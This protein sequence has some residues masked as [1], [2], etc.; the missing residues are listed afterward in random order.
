M[1][2][3]AVIIAIA[4]GCSINALNATN[5]IATIS[6]KEVVVNQTISPFCLS[7]LKGDYETA[8]KLIDLGADINAKSLGLTPAMYAA[9]FNRTDILKL[10][11]EKGAKLK[12]KSDKGMTA[13]KYAELSNATDALSYL[14]QLE[15]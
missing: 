9:K 10:L 1:K 5:E 11:V 12:V 13:E 2:K 8:K 6:T 4:L 14:R 3:T 15:S 7:I